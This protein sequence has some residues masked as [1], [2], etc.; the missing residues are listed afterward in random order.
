[1]CNTGRGKYRTT[2]LA[3]GS[4]GLCPAVHCLLGRASLLLNMLDCL[5]LQNDSEKTS[6]FCCVFQGTEV[7]SE[8]SGRCVWDSSVVLSI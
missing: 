4:T 8:P 1:M 3:D 6:L 7:T 5:N 2:V